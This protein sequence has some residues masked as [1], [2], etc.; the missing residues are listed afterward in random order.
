MYIDP[1]VPFPNAKQRSLHF[2]KH[3]HKFGA[4][5]EFDYERMADVFMSSPMHPNMHECYRATGT[6]DR[7]RLDALTRFFGVAYHG[8]VLRTFHPRNAHEIALKG[9]PQKFVLFKCSEAA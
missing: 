2:V 1:T 4:V 5:D 6:L 7:I 8:M 3:G 9:G